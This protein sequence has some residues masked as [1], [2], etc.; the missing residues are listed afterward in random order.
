MMLVAARAI[1]RGGKGRGCSLKCRVVC[2]VQCPIRAQ[3]V[4]LTVGE[5]TVDDGEEVGDFAWCCPVG[6]DPAVSL[7]IAQAHAS[8]RARIGQA[9]S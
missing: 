8:L 1:S 2:D 4:S 5:V 9:L 6:G 3:A 7:P